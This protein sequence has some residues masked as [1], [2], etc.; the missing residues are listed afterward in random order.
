MTR[1]YFVMSYICKLI[2]S[3]GFVSTIFVVSTCPNS[4]LQHTSN[5]ADTNESTDGIEISELTS[6]TRSQ[7]IGKTS[8][9]TG[10]GSIKKKSQKMGDHTQK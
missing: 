1:A 9:T 7:K 2:L 10:T 6:D 3:T 4:F 8:S 5:M